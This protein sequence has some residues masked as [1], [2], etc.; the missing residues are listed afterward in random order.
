MHE[1]ARRLPTGIDVVSY[2]PG[3]VP[4]TDLARDADPVTR[5]AM[6]RIMP[7]LTATPLATSPA[8][9]GRF[10]AD[11]APGGIDAPSGAYVDRSRVAPSSHESYDPERELDT[12]RTADALTAAW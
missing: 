8:R 2:N 11:A 4:G 9:A 1:W 12:W 10:L 5:F 6:R 7:L 3:L